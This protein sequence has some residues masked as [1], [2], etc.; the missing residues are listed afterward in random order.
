MSTDLDTRLLRTL[1]GQADSTTQWVTPGPVLRQQ[2]AARTR[3]RRQTATVAA[4]AVTVAAVLAG[5]LTLSHGPR[6][7]TPAQPT[8]SPTASRADQKSALLQAEVPVEAVHD[9][10]MQLALGDAQLTATAPMPRSGDTAMLFTSRLPPSTGSRLTAY[11]VT[12][13]GK[14]ARAG[15]VATIADSDVGVIALPV[16]DLDATALLVVSSLWPDGDVQVTTAAPGEQPNIRP[17]R[18]QDG[19]AVVS[20]PGPDVITGLRVWVTDSDRRLVYEHIPGGLLPV[21]DPTW[22]PQIV[23]WS[24]HDQPQSVQ[25]RTDGTTACRFTVAGFNSPD[26]FVMDWNL[27]D[28]ACAPVDGTLRLLLADDRRYSSVT[29]IAPTGTATVRLRWRDGSTT[30]VPVSP[31]APH[32]FIDTSGH[33]PDRLTAAEALAADGHVTANAGP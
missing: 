28:D 16:R 7:A 21:A 4:T 18:L 5:V 11:T 20:V 26:V 22:L 25:V 27:F 29:G 14:T 6:Q 32:A 23:A 17:A 13:D 3:R 2:A 31:D 12:Y 8:P 19:I 24:G 10:K 15:T 9:M 1:R 30:D 33:R